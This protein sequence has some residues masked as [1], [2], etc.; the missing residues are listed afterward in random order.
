MSSIIS[1]PSIESV[2]KRSAKGLRLLDLW[3]FTYDGSYPGKDL[4]VQLECDVSMKVCWYLKWSPHKKL[5]LRSWYSRNRK[6]ETKIHRQNCVG[7]LFSIQNWQIT[8]IKG[9]TV[10]GLGFL[11]EKTWFLIFLNQRSLTAPVIQLS[12]FRLNLNRI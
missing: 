10:V 9:T 3:W 8:V 6:S 1:D 7:V 4:S 12:T 11:L 2:F 5:I